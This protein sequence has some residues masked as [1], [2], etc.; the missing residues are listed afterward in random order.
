M[1]AE[2]TG[3]AGAS[4]RVSPPQSGRDWRVRKPRKSSASW[5]LSRVGNPRRRSQWALL[6][7]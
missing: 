7:C 5:N 1:I 6:C 3:R 2:P 4:P